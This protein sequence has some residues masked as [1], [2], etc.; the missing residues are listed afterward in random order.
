MPETYHVG[1][2]C[3]AIHVWLVIL[4][5]VYGI[6]CATLLQNWDP[7]IDP[8]LNSWLTVFRMVISQYSGDWMN[9][10]ETLSKV[11]HYTPFWKLNAFTCFVAFS[12][13]KDF[14]KSV[15]AASRWCFG[16]H[17]LEH[18]YFY[19][20]SCRFG[21][22]LMC[23]FHWE[24]DCV[25]FSPFEIWRCGCAAAVAAAYLP[26]TELRAPQG[27]H[28]TVVTCPAIGEPCVLEANGKHSP[29]QAWEQGDALIRLLG[30]CQSWLSVCLDCII[31]HPSL[32]PLVGSFAL[33]VVVV[34]LASHCVFQQNH[35]KQPKTM[36]A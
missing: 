21:I 2:C 3:K 36:T 33:T 32:H 5:M 7:K 19:L 17:V 27:A 9:S 31:L 28:A 13:G 18:W 10:D 1:K 16:R 6:G 23:Q 12:W 35:S 11:N 30:T 25:G 22:S 24:L 26:T 14:W 29:C 15:R 20:H 34:K 4:A 8:A